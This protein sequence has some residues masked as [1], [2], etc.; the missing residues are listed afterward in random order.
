MDKSQQCPQDSEIAILN[1]L[2][3]EKESCLPRAERSECGESRR[4]QITRVEALS[5]GWEKWREFQEMTQHLRVL[6]S[7]YHLQAQEVMGKEESQ[8]KDA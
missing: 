3:F 6:T 1:R 8:E 5:G 2:L 4:E 7:R